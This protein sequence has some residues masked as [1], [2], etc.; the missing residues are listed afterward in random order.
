MKPLHWDAINPQTGTPFT[1]DD[2]NL[3]WGDSAYYLEPG[4]PGYVPYGPTPAPVKPPR[5]K[6]FRRRKT[7][8]LPPEPNPYTAMS[9]FKYHVAPKSLGGFTTRAALADAADTPTLLAGIATD[10][11]TTPEI[12]EAVLRAAFGKFLAC[13]AGCEWSP[14]FLDLVT[15]RPTSGGSAPAPDAFHNADDLNASVSIAFLASAIDTWQAGLTLQSLGEVG[16]VTPTVDSIIR[17][18]DQA[19]DKYTPGGMIQVRGDYMNFDPT[20]VTQ[21][22]FFTA[23]AAAEV[24]ATDYAA[25]QPQSIIVLV[26][27]A[28]SGPLTVRVASHINGSVRSYTYTNL[29]TTP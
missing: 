11:G 14:N 8:P 19:V 29:I 24:R 6:P 28:L 1:W 13:A 7:T 12:A 26:P 18:S 9:T 5:K 4:D 3:F 23:G 22:V 17:Q 16:K 2:P 21:G 15:F 27:A 25:R 10:A 20:D